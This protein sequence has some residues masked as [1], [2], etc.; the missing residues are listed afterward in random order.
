ME[1]KHYEYCRRLAFKAQRHGGF[2]AFLCSLRSRLVDHTSL[3]DLG[4]AL[5]R[6]DLDRDLH[7]YLQAIITAV[8]D[9]EIGFSSATSKAVEM[10]S[11]TPLQDVSVR[12]NWSTFPN[13]DKIL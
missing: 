3:V 7:F 6:Q 12:G 11:V 9:S 4:G 1:S 10:H 8:H 5:L 2:E 13:F